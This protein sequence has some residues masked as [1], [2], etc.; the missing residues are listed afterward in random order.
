MPG[1]VPNEGEQ[2][3]LDLALSAENV[4]TFNTNTDRG[5]DL[6]L[7]L[8]TNSAPGDTITEATIT[9]PTGGGYARKTLT[10]GSWTSANPMTYAV[11][12]FS[13]SGGNYS[14]SIYGYF[15]ATKPAGTGTARILAIEVDGNGPYTLNDGDTYDITPQISAE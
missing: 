10:D 4:S 1:F 11:Q 13:P 2:V 5:A 3:F 8:F 15:I 7:G 12:Q 14:G 9:E 6:E